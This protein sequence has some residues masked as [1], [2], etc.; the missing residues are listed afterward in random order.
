[1]NAKQKLQNKIKALTTS[2]IEAAL[3][4]INKAWDKFTR[5]E[6]IVR[7][8]MLNEY[9]QRNG[10]EMVDALMDKLEATA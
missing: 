8:A 2:Q 10:G 7:V 5:E 4:V 6:L 1:M 3:V 9:E